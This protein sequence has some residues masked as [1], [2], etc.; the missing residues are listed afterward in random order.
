MKKIRVAPDPEPM[1]EGEEP[2]MHTLFT[3]GVEVT[4]DQ[5]LE[6][7]ASPR[8]CNL[9]GVDNTNERIIYEHRREWFGWPEMPPINP[10]EEEL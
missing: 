5:H 7:L 9:L 4:M 8:K 2:S 1:V 6:L 10:D 3:C